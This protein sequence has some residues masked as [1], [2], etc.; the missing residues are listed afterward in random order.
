MAWKRARQ[1]F[2][3]GLTAKNRTTIEEMLAKA[4]KAI[5]QVMCTAH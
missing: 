4:F 2:Y 3:Q 1:Q 5:G